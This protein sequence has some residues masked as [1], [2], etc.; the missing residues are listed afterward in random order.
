MP[1]SERERRY[2]PLY[3]VDGVAASPDQLV[4]T[5]SGWSEPVPVRC[6]NGHS[7]LG[8]NKALVGWIPCPAPAAADGSSPT[9]T[10]HRTHQCRN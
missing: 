10:G 1:A 8:D 7:L 3:A 4:R 2:R 9:R 5:A 6:Y